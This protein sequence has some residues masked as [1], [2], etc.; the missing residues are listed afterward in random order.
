MRE[1]LR[2]TGIDIIGDV[3]WGTHLCLFYQTKQDLLD[4]LIPYFKTGLENN[5]F[6]MWVTSEP[7]VA[8]EAKNSLIGAIKNLDDY[9]KN[10]QIEILDYSQWYTKLGVFEPDKVLKGWIEKEEQAVKKGFDGLRMTGNTAWLE[11]KYWKDFTDYEATVNSVIG[12]HRMLAI[13]TYSLKDCGALEIID[14]VSN[15]QFALIKRK[16]RWDII[17]SSD[18]KK[19]EETLQ[20]QS[21]FLRNVLESLAH[22]FYVMDANDYKIIMANSAAA[23]ASHLR[24][25]TCYALTH[26][27]DKPCADEHVC[28]LAELKKTKKPVIVEHTHYD[29]DGNPRYIEIHAY[30]LFDK[31][32]NVIQMIECCLDITERKK[33]EE[34][35]KLSEERYKLA[36][37]VANIGSWDWDIQTGNLQWSE[38]IEPMFGFGRGQFRG[39]YEAFLG[40]VHPQDRQHVVNSVNACIEEGRDYDIDHRI[41]WPNGVVRWV[42]E[43]GNVIRD[44]DN[45]AIRMLGIVKDITERKKTEEILKRDK[46]S[47]EKLVNQKTEELLK[48]QKELADARRLSDIGT[49]AATVAHELRNPL[50][51]MQTAAYNIR[52]KKENPLLDKHLDHIEK[53]ISESD[54]IINNLLF[55]SRLKMP[56]YENV[57][58]YDTLSEC[59]TS[60]KKRFREQKVFVDKRF[61]SIKGNFIKADPF[62]VMEIF[63]NILNNAYQ[64]LG[65]KKGKIEIRAELDMKGLIKI[66]FKD[67]GVGIDKDDLEKVFDPFFTRR[68]KGTGLGLT[69][70]YQIVRLHDGKIEIKSTKNKG[71]TVTVVLPI[72]RRCDDKKSFDN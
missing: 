66:I 1:K 59:I 47:F 35:L 14:V 33:T 61:K 67:N 58:I 7:L 54:Q 64:A 34:A 21:E 19:A 25:P 72:K 51:V 20:Q 17:E 11:K 38:T 39:T 45:K 13:C 9:I 41:V 40:C 48:T 6:C 60:A 50:G 44:K 70:C 30:P 22:P 23:L 71:T 63:N 49:L 31:E 15:H 42:S 65:D 37:R 24:V 16:N 5:E 56:H 29:K 12:K 18:R 36:Q 55:Y 26:K 46:E 69:V 57:N 3:S 52:R 53:K 62:Q 32:G 27:S 2:K 10:G 4:I 8:E 68:S 43:T 28:P